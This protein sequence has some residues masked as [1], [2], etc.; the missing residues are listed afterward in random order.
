MSLIHIY[1]LDC[2]CNRLSDF[3]FLEEKRDKL[4]NTAGI[5]S[6]Y[7]FK[8]LEALIVLFNCS[9]THFVAIILVLWS[10]YAIFC[11]ADFSSDPFDFRP[12]KW[13]K[14]VTLREH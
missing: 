12:P 9:Q 7:S 4:G 14:M 3:T 8:D 5:M 6:L 11:S 10:F 2:S 13:D 1:C